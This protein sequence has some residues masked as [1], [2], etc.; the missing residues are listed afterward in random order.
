MA[1]AEDKYREQIEIE[2]LWIATEQGQYVFVALLLLSLLLIFGLWDMTS[3]ALLMIWFAVLTTVNFIRWMILRYF[4]RHKAVLAGNIQQVKRFFIVSS[5]L[6][7]LCWGSAAVLFLQPNNAANVVIVTITLNI[8]I[9]G[10]IL[11][12]FCYLP[13]AIAI[14]IPISLPL[15]VLLILEGGKAYIATSLILFLLA[16]LSIKSSLNIAKM[17]NHALRLNFENAALRIE[18]EEKSL[19]LETALENMNQGISLSDQEDRLRM[20]NNKFTD[21]LGEKARAKVEENANLSSLLNEA[22]PPML[23]TPDGGT[24]YQLPDGQVYEIHQSQLSHGGRVL[25]YTNISERIKRE[26]ALEKANASKTRFL[27]AA[28]H[29]LR[30]PIHALGLFFDELSD[31]VYSPETAQVISQIEDSITAISSM[32]NALLDISKLDAGVIKP[33]FDTVPLGEMLA[34]LQKEFAYIASENGNRLH[35]RVTKLAAMSDPAMLERMLRNL[36][37][38]A[39]R[40]TENGRVIV[41]ARKRGKT[42]HIQV[43]DN[44]SGIPEDQLDEI[45]VEFHQLQNPARDRRQ[46]LGLGLSIVK[47]LCQLLQHEINVRSKLGKGSCFS[48]SLPIAVIKPD[49]S[50]LSGLSTVTSSE[51]KDFLYDS[52]SGCSVLV[53]E[54]DVAVLEGMNALLKRWGCNVT[55]S[56]SLADAEATLIENQEKLDILIVDYRLPGNVSGID[57]VKRIQER[58]NYPF[59][60]L[61]ITG[62]TAPDRLREAEDSGFPLLHKPVQPAKLR[63]TLRYL[64]DHAS[65]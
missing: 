33:K 40:Y 38:N 59:A 20:W 51:P 32:L 24:E 56:A 16:L 13:A 63:N 41:A 54:D 49:L 3:H 53:L 22:S 64:L 15:I 42:I 7:G 43:I 48:I 25:T 23:P 5:T 61:I 11:T 62:D 2:R 27:A 10:A 37:G 57:A 21:L 60:V 46:G 39:L 52:L 47:L 14:L 30:Q 17:L 26:Q 36:I 50:D 29:D 12:W 31:Q 55:T 9:I 35:I 65:R 19:L 4:Y 44:G 34:R 6:I 18:S 8:E 58:L 1:N 28:S 45:F